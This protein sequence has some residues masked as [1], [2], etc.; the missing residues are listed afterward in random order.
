MQVRRVFTHIWRINAVIILLGG[1]LAIVL[2]VAM[3]MLLAKE[4]LRTR[5]VS[6]VATTQ[7]NEVKK[8]AMQLGDFEGFA[9]TP[10][11]RAPLRRSQTYALDYAL[12]SVSKEAHSDINY[13]FFN[14]QS[15]EAHWLRPNHTAIILRDEHFFGFGNEDEDPEAKEK[16][17]VRLFL[18]Q[19]V[20][21][22][23]N[24]DQR[25]TSEDEKTIAI[26]APSG[27]GYRVVAEAVAELYNSRFIAENRF[28][29]LYAAPN[30]S[31]T[32]FAVEFDPF[33]PAANVEK[34]KV[35]AWE[36]P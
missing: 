35:V 26:S 20:E 36:S 29:L 13:L 14:P 3:L 24:G 21:R 17:E 18:Y 9:G 8:T 33:A 1:A 32:L 5:Y 19:I 6:D 15:R 16:R 23:S 31:N 34:Y 22:D 27:Q 2:L 30:V 28:L 12:S 25:L 7:L 4:Y 10:V 11:L